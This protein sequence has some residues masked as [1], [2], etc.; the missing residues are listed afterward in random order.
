MAE[1]TR[2]VDFVQPL[3]LWYDTNKRDLPWRR[4][5]TP[6]RV[7]VSE[8]MLQQ[9]RVEAVKPYFARFM[10]ALPTVEALASCDPER[11]NKLWEGLGYY[12]RVRNMQKAAQVIVCDYGGVIP[13]DYE[14]L[15]ALPGIGSYTAGA[16]A[17]FA[18]GRPE[19]AVDGN[20]L[21]VLARVT[22]DA[23]NVLDPAVKR[24][25][26]AAVRAAIP[27][28]RAG[29][30]NQALIELGATVCGPNLA[31]DC[32]ACPLATVCRARAEGKQEELPH[33]EKKKARRVEEKTIL[34]I[35]DGG[36]TLV[37]RRPPTGLLAGLYE[38]PSC[39]GHICES[40]VLA[41]VR[42]LGLEPLRMSPLC[43]AK[44][45]FTHIEWRMKG[46]VITVADAA[47]P[48]NTPLA[49]DPCEAEKTG[50][51][52]ALG[53]RDGGAYIFADNTALKDT[54]AVPSAYGAYLATLAVERGSRRVKKQ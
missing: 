35:R 16:V 37:H 52:S 6:Y 42:A 28:D 9:T 45:I 32:A 12:S 22:A 44:H 49:Q 1:K 2:L 15:L 24:D 8:I 23:R 5:P 40:E 14:A 34:L 50:A 27:Q 39:E 31:P 33:R 25:Y 4:E 17:S 10:Q 3:L 48:A 13:A 41:R 29:D 20:V 18:Y 21:R 51:P 19:P 38:F 53:P 7:W 36:H 43:D 54:Y 46:W 26:E 30:Y 11:L 47:L